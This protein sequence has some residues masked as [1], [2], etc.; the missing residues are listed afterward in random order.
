MTT[1]STSDSDET[2]ARVASSSVRRDASSAPSFDGG[3]GS[4]PSSRSWVERV[5][6]RWLFALVGV[7]LLAAITYFFSVSRKYDLD[8]VVYRSA[9]SWWWNG[10]DPY[11]HL[12]SIHHLAFTYPPF[13]LLA[14]GPLAAIPAEL[15][16]FLWFLISLVAVTASLFIVFKSLRW[17]TSLDLWLVAAALSCAALFIIE[18][19]RSTFDYG[20]VNA[21][22]L[23][24]CLFDTLWP[25]FRLRGVLV[26]CAAAIKLTPVIFVLFFAIKRDVKAIVR[27]AVAFVAATGLA[28]LVLPGPSH[29]FWTKFVW[30][31]ERTGKLSYPGNLS[32]DAV[33]VRIGLSSADTRYLWAGL[34][35]VT[36]V[37]GV[38]AASRCVK[39][40]SEVGGVLMVAITGLL[41]SPVSWS[42]H[43]IWMVMIVPLLLSPHELH[44]NVRV[45]LVGLLALVVLAPY[46]WFAPGWLASVAEAITPIWAF[47]VLSV[48]AA[49]AQRSGAMSTEGTVASPPQSVHEA[50][51]ADAGTA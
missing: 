41:V 43:W 24:G 35:M 27:A 16:K 45:V 51:P 40:G 14:L 15:A 21:V 38:V 20:Q 12:Y 29:E 26:G 25:R 30:E 8:L 42:H 48:T 9:I 28:W 2:A 47:V 6:R 7:L 34:A 50:S 44:R 5:P 19:V 4:D 32:W 13:A 31:P 11:R 36:L 17:R 10:H 3:G 46:W 39:A 49:S 1:K 37:V 22:I 23:V 33:S 18:P